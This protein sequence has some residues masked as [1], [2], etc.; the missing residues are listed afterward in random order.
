MNKCIHLFCII[1]LLYSCYF[2]PQKQESFE[3]KKKEYN[4]KIILESLL[5]KELPNMKSSNNKLYL[6]EVNIDKSMFQ[7]NYKVEATSMLKSAYSLEPEDMM[8]I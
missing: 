6:P 8:V 1:F 5:S 3:T 2:K 4:F 7:E